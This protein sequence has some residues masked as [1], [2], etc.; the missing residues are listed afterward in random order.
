MIDEGKIVT[1]VKIGDWVLDRRFV[2]PHFCRVS[3]ISEERPNEVWVTPQASP[4]NIIKLDEEDVAPIPLTEKVLKKNGFVHH[5]DQEDDFWHIPN[6]N[7]G[8]DVEAGSFVW[9][10]SKKLLAV[11]ELQHILWVLGFDDN[12]KV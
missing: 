6:Q 9:L 3:I 7:F 4:R 12:L 2:A 11:H 1:E 10:N 5:K 8:I